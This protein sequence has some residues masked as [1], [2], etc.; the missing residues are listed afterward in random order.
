MKRRNDQLSLLY[1]CYGVHCWYGVHCRVKSLLQCGK[2]R[3]HGFDDVAQE[4][5]AFL[6]TLH[7]F[8]GGLNLLYMLW[9]I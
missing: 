1:E 5:L 4:L 7:N 9:S 2:M 6:S 8:T 3:W